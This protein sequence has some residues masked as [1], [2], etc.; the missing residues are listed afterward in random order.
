MNKSYFSEIITKKS[1]MLQAIGCAIL[2]TAVFSW[3]WFNCLPFSGYSP[4]IND[5]ETLGYYGRYLIYAQ[6]PVGFP[7]GVIKGLSFPFA[8][9]ANVMRGPIPLFAI[10][11]KVLSRIC[12]SLAEF[13]YFVPVELL[14]V[15]FSAIFAWGLSREFNAKSFWTK[16]LATTLSGLSVIMLH[17]SS[18]YYGVTFLMMHTPLYLGCAYFYVRLHKYREWKAGLLLAC[19]IMCASLTD[20]Y[21]LSGIALGLTCCIAVHLLEMLLRSS[22]RKRI[23]RRTLPVI[24][25]FMIGLLASIMVQGSLGNSRN[26]DKVNIDRILDQRYEDVSSRY[27]SYGGGFGGG[28]HVADVLSII[29]PPRDNENLPSNYRL[30]PTAL[31]ARLGFPITAAD[32]Q[33]GQYEGFAYVGTIPLGLWAAA[34]IV[35]A[36]ALLRKRRMLLTRLWLPITAQLRSTGDNDSLIRALVISCVAMYTVSWGYIIHIGGHRLYTILTPSF[37]MT[38]L[39]PQFMYS[40]SIGRYAWPLSILVVLTGVALFERYVGRR[41]FW[42]GRRGRIAFAMLVMVCIAAHVYEISGYLRQTPVT[43]GNEISKAFSDADV[44]T[45]KDTVRD[46]VA[47]MIVPAFVGNMEWTRTS[48]ALAFH[49]KISISGATI[50]SPGESAH[51]LLQYARDIDDISAGKLRDVVKRYGNICVACPAD[52]AQKILENSDLPL[53]AHRLV[54]RNCVIFTLA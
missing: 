46:K 8:D 6:E 16:L 40:R 3:R 7:L 4:T 5:F 18:R 43:Q 45:I 53:K 11:L 41:L 42:S 12:P 39:L 21:I 27:S 20:Y 54:S 33:D 2:V 49:G 36:V 38:C 19:V 15:F 1:N 14:S 32:L 52:I 48:Y 24:V 44:R 51:D 26:L 9:V 17:K 47:I 37:I 30:G 10:P 35:S 29:I 13:Y 50:G 22:Q 31:F 25:A 34:I 23:F 28:F